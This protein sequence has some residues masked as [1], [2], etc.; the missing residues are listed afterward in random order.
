MKMWLKILVVTALAL[1]VLQFIRPQKNVAATVSSN[2]ISASADV[3]QIL[4]QSCDDCHSNNTTYPW[5]SNIQPVGW[6]LAHHVDEGKREL[7]FDEFATY[8][9]RKK[10]HKLE[11]TEE[12]VAEKEM[13]LPSYLWTHK[14]A[15]LTS[16]QQQA[17]IKWSKDLRAELELT[18]PKDSLI[19]K[20]PK[21]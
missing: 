19:F 3:E 7:N 21:R 16:E 11:E 12:V 2:R 20:K 15:T 5:Y 8:S 17:L 14:Q 18:Y 6:W 13:P 1:V 9:P 10:Y 4:K